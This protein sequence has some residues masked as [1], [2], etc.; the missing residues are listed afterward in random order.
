MPTPLS[1][2]RTF[3]E[4]TRLL[5]GAFQLDHSTSMTEL[6][7]VFM[8]DGDKPLQ[9]MKRRLAEWYGVAWVFPST[10]GTTAL[11][12]LALMSACR[13]GGRVLVNRDAHSSVMAAMIHGGFEP[14]YF[15]PRYDA[16]LGLCVGPTIAGFREVMESQ[17]LDCVFLTS[18]N[19]F[20]IVG[21]L[22]GIIAA[23]HQRG[24][25]VVVDAAHAPHFHF[26]SR[27]PAAAEDLHAEYVTQSTHKVASALSQG[28][29]LLLRDTAQ[30]APLYENVNE[31]GLISTSFS[32]PILAS[33]ELGVRQ[34]V[35]QGDELWRRTVDRAEAFRSAARGLPGIDCFG[36]EQRGKPG[37]NAFD[38]TRI[39]L[40]V[41]ALGLSGFAF[42]RRLHQLGIYPEM[43]TLQHVLFLVTPGTTD[44][45]LRKLYQAIETIAQCQRGLTRPSWP[46]P[47]PLPHMAMI[48]RMAKFAPKHVVG[49][50]DAVGR[51]AGETIATYPPGIPIVAAGEVLS[52]ETIEY[53]RCMR[54]HGAVLKGASDPQFQRIKV[55]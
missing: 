51:I 9:Q 38:P 29:L 46:P 2:Q 26:C 44:E 7:S 36:S 50:A 39:T 32:Y 15:T 41:G 35:E 52:A 1:R 40:D 37:F 30:I 19:Y 28:S 18:P 16:Q 8:A 48:P 49:V 20:G 25:P 6:G 14:V 4:G 11:N 45:D 13:P 43:A 21:E 53:L 34:L 24:L 3:R 17:E 42:E 23:A 12:V 22:E 33:L 54:R 10:H 55:L 27:L 31:L 47:P 5:K